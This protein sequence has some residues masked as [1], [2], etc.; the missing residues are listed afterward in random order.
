MPRSHCITAAAVAGSRV[1]LRRLPPRRFSSLFHPVPRRS[2]PANPRGSS[3]EPP[4][5][6][7]HDP[8]G[9][10]PEFDSCLAG[11]L[12]R[13]AVGPVRACSGPP[14]ISQN[15]YGGHADRRRPGDLAGPV[16][17]LAAGQILL[18]LLPEA[19]HLRPH[20]GLSALIPQFVRPH[21][22]GLLERSARLWIMLGG[23][24]ILVILGLI[25]DRR[26]LNWRL[27]LAVQSGVAIGTVL[28]GWRM[29]ILLGHPGSP[30]Y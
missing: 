7:G 11:R 30:V 26:G 3:R 12:C 4:R 16:L 25:D 10:R 18:L 17:P 23:G 5:R 15:P 2:P 29:S 9:D 8:G 22:P 14:G 6:V 28:L 24:T 13:P 19:Q 21:L 20:G 27:R 1:D